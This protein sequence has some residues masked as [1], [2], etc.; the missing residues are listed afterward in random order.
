MDKG[1]RNPTKIMCLHYI[2]TVWS[3]PTEAQFND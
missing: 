1:M 3:I 2:Y